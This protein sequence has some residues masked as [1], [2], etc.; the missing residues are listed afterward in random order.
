MK[1]TRICAWSDHPKHCV[2][3]DQYPTR[4]SHNC[5]PASTLP[6]TIAL[7]QLT[8]SIS[9][10]DM[11]AVNPQAPTAME[12]STTRRICQQA[13][14]MLLFLD[15]TKLINL[16][17]QRARAVVDQVPLIFLFTH[18]KKAMVF[19]LAVASY[20][21]YQIQYHCMMQVL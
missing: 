18:K 14:Q 17:T 10:D 8:I 9:Q 16:A 19:F 7:Q 12:G 11:C 5:P 1:E 4:P 6:L 15:I 20:L 21:P 13:Y 3:L 2:Y